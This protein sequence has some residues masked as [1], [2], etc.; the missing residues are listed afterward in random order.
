MP[1]SDDRD[2]SPADGQA[3]A[4]D[5]SAATQTIEAA[6]FRPTAATASE[7]RT[8]VTPLRL[9]ALGVVLAVAWLLWFLFTAKSVR[10]ESEPQ[11]QTLAVEGGFAFQI[12]QTYLLNEGEYRVRATA[13]GYHDLQQTIEVGEQRNQIFTLTLTKLPG[14]ITFETEPDNATVTVAGHEDLEAQ[15]PVTLLLPAGEHVSH[16]RHDRYQTATATFEVVGMDNAQT[17]TQTLAPNWANVTIPTRPA[18]ASLL[19]DDEDSGSVSP[20]PVEILAGEHRVTAQLAG[21]KTWTDIVDV[22]AGVDLL[23]PAVVLEPAAAVVA[24]ASTPSGAGITVN[25]V[26]RGETPLDVDLEPG[27]HEILARKVGH[28]TVSRTLNAVSGQ[29]ERLSLTLPSLQGELAI[30]T[31]PEDAELVIDGVA[32]GIASGTRTLPAI[33]HEIEIRKDGYASYRKTVTPQ[34]GFTQ[35]L[36]VRLLTLAEARLEALKKVRQTSAGQELVLLSPGTLRMGASRREP[37]RRANE[38]LRQVNLTR[39]FYL[40]RH[41]VTNGQFRAFAKGH[42][43]GEFQNIDLD[44]NLQPVVRVSWTEAA[45]Y[46]NWLS[47]QDSL[48][49][50]YQE[51]FGKITGFDASALGYRLPTEA[52]WAWAA[53]HLEGSDNPR[54]FAWGETLPPPDR[55]GNY[56]DR[57][58]AHLVARIIFGYDDNHIVSAPVGTFAANVYGIYDMGGNVSEWTHDYYQITDG[59]DVDDPLGP[60]Q[61]EY[62]VIRGASWQ[63]GTITDLRLSFRD[64]GVDGRQDLGFRIARFA[65]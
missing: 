37:G 15:T 57:S 3:P 29:R 42:S 46:C 40:S 17:V 52:E 56:A 5:P 41:E 28:G 19:I 59:S 27:R 39:L 61:G 32:A 20:G 13:N 31:Q 36:K 60:A 10:F 2:R 8:V 25:G 26:F 7:R 64:Y 30:E 6:R 24:I 54:R 4:N 35:A 43:S 65:E 47:R 11:A 45:Q 55:H 62:H 12:G 1:P 14:R 50:F 63:K 33:A 38:T 49:P 23:L 53:R 34:P 18:G 51:E 21:H 16:I 58:A 44:Q 9:V 48:T 22:Q